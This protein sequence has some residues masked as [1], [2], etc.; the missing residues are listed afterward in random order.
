M[1]T[2]LVIHRD[3]AGIPLSRRAAAHCAAGAGRLLA[4]LPPRHLRTVLSKLR[5][6]A[7]PA[8]QEQA[9]SALAAVV[10]VSVVCAGQGCLPRSI[11]TAL[12]CRARGVWPTWC[13]G[14]RVEPFYAHAWVEA[15]GTMVGER[16]PKEYFRV[17]MS[18]PPR[19][20][21]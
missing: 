16:F 18:V 6:G 15:E 12:L 14:V 10:A 5:A 8:N 21:G 17:L 19:R 3:R 7:A 20:A 9:G 13:V 1:T 2:P 4:K 11:A